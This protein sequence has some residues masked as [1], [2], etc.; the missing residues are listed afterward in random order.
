MD[1]S[2]QLKC[3]TGF[4]TV[5]VLSSNGST[6]IVNPFVYVET[7]VAKCVIKVSGEKSVRSVI[8][9]VLKSDAKRSAQ[10][11]KGFRSIETFVCISLKNA[12]GDS[13]TTCCTRKRVFKYSINLFK[14]L[15]KC[16]AFLIFPGTASVKI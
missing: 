11:R 8:S 7:N 3:N 4:K 12:A 14:K 10:N 16:S 5:G 9:I 15:T 6:I 2:K 13:C 1:E